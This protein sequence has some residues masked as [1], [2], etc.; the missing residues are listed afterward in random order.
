MGLDCD[1]W[2]TVR[3]AEGWRGWVDR[4]G[5]STGRGSADSGTEVLVDFTYVRK[6]TEKWWRMSKGLHGLFFFHC[7]HA[8]PSFSFWFECSNWG[9]D[10]WWGNICRHA[11]SS[12]ELSRV[13]NFLLMT[14]DSL[15]KRRW[16]VTERGETV[17]LCLFF[18]TDSCLCNNH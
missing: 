2:S 3:I 8:K 5:Q 6:V 17:H 4:Q 7:L 16:W 1:E 18:K 13:Q 14:K 9:H 12:G 15:G 10:G 11:E